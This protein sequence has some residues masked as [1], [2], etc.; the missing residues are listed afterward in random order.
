MIKWLFGIIVFISIYYVRIKA[1]SILRITGSSAWVR[2]ACL[3]EYSSPTL[4]HKAPKKEG[5]TK[6]TVSIRHAK[7]DQKH[8]IVSLFSLLALFYYSHSMCGI[9]Y[10]VEVEIRVYMRCECNVTCSDTAS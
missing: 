7:L 4:Y 9:F 10:P 3:E 1:S 5:N 2:S 8:V 6:L